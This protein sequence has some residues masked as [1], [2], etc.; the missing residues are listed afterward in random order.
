MSIELSGLD[1]GNPLGFLAALGVVNA[2]DDAGVPVRLAWRDVGVWRPNLWGWDGGLEALIERLDAD[3][4]SC[5]DEPA[6]KINYDGTRD[7]KPPPAEFRRL[8]VEAAAACSSAKRRSVDWLAAF[9]TDVAVDNN[10]NTKPTALHFTAGQQQFLKMVL[11]LQDQVTPDDLTEAL[12]G[13]WRSARDLP[14]MG[15]DA[16]VAREYALRATNP[17]KAKDKLGTPGADWLAVRGLAS[18]GVVP[19]GDSVLTTGCSGSWKG[20]RFAWPLWTVPLSRALIGTL[21]RLPLAA[22]AE[23]ERR[24]RGIGAVLSCA[25][26][27][28]E[29]GGYG[30]FSPPR[31]V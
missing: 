17:A 26:R 31:P 1:G 2:L 10:G 14:V 21:L 11:E 15:W 27:R 3:R 20:G 18:I 19:R 13:A 28:S 6:L 22:M 16:T 5:A 8:L 12:R 30:S 7:L 4:V 9:A 23:S 24:A 29:Q 25:I